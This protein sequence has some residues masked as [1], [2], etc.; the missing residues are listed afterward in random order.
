MRL[1]AEESA[2]GVRLWLALDAAWLPQ[3]EAIASHL[4]RAVAAQ[5]L[6]LL[7]LSCNGRPLATAQVPSIDK[8]DACPSAP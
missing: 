4:R 8:E 3:S 6:R 7:G 1:H 2:Q 5:G